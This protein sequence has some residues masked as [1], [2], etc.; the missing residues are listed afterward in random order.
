MK[1]SWN[2][3]FVKL[4][5]LFHLFQKRNYLKNFAGSKRFDSTYLWKDIAECYSFTSNLE[6]MKQNLEIGSCRSSFGPLF[7]KW[8]IRAPC[9]FLMK[10]P[11]NIAFLQLLYSFI[12]SNN[13]NIRKVWQKVSSLIHLILAK[14]VVD[15]PALFQI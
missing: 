13:K 4:L 10:I 2:I 12:C 5:S 9:Q 1:I 14:I 7:L 8:R 15:P 11:W 3:T 6:F